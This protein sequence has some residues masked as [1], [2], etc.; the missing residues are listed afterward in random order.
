MG[1]LKKKKPAEQPTPVVPQPQT[2]QSAQAAQGEISDAREALDRVVEELNNLQLPAFEEKM[3]RAAMKNEENADRNAQIREELRASGAADAYEKE[4]Q[5]A[6]MDGLYILPEELQEY[7]QMI[8]AVIGAYSLNMSAAEACIDGAN[9]IDPLLLPYVRKFGEALSDGQKLKADVCQEVLKYAVLVVH[10]RPVEGKD[11]E[12]RRKIIDLRKDTIEHVFWGGVQTAD[13]V[14]AAMEAL[15][16]YQE[17]YEKR[18]V[19]YLENFQRKLDAIPEEYQKMFDTIG[20]AGADKLPIN[21]PLRKFLAI[22]LGARSYLYRIELAQ[23]N[24]EVI[25]AKIMRLRDWL[26]QFRSE[27]K[28][29]FVTEQ[30]IGFNEEETMNTLRHINERTI[31]DINDIN[32]MQE[33]SAE[34]TKEFESILHAAGAMQGIVDEAVSAREY[35]KHSERLLAA[36]ADFNKLYTENLNK[37]PKQENEPKVIET[38]QEDNRILADM[39]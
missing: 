22:E 15:R 17:E 35:R 16:V 3:Q 11:D 37:P 25:T 4:D 23:L 19:E 9:E 24:M 20:F 29:R 27:T 12:T 33:R 5:L 10:K 8:K 7:R 36:G 18:R 6:M 28:K 26:E 31:R 13:A 39:G 14:Y 30:A 21:H 32:G 2:I 34:M 1:F 38:P